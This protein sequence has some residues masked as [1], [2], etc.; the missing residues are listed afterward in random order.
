LFNFKS[1]KMTKEQVLGLIRHT[2]TFVGGILIVQGIADEGMITE[3]IGAVV[4]AVGAVWSVV[5]NKPAA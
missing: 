2:L 1:K 5:K 4:T 3:A